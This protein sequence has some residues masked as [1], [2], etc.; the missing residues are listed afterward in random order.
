MTNKLI[1]KSWT[2]KNNNEKQKCWQNNKQ[3]WGYE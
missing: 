3:H 2:W 1:R